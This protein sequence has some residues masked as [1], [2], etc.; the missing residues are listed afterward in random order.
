MINKLSS[1]LSRL[2][3]DAGRKEPGPADQRAEPIPNWSQARPPWEPDRSAMVFALPE[4]QISIFEPAADPVHYYRIAS[5]VADEHCDRSIHVGLL[6]NGASKLV[7]VFSSWGGIGVYVDALR[8]IAG[9]LW[10]DTGLPSDDI[11]PL[12]TVSNVADPGQ[13]IADLTPFN[14]WISR[15]R[16]GEFDVV[17]CDW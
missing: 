17:Y 4:A 12:M 16:S 15:I 3:L 2:S 11:R 13:Y 8:K 14:R 10:A 9:T 5:T 7:T 6:S 1:M